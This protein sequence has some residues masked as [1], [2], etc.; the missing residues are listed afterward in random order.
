MTTLSLPRLQPRLQAACVTLPPPLRFAYAYQPI[1]DVERKT[2]FGHEALVRGPEGQPAST[3]LEQVTHAMRAQFES[4]SRD[5]AIA[6]AAALGIE[7]VLS[8]N[9]MPNHILDVDENIEQIL[10]ASCRYGLPTNRLMLETNEGEQVADVKRLVRMMDRCRAFG[11]LAA[12]DDFGGG[13][14]GLSLLANYQP[15]LIKLDM[16]L[17]RNIDRD[18]ARRAIVAGI[19]NMCRE[20]NVAVV[21][22]G[23]ETEG[24]QAALTDLGISLMQGFLFGK[25]M[26]RPF[27]AVRSRLQA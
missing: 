14:S 3:V 15:D 17:V 21:A 13:F 10:A 18:P 9:I 5:K 16:A 8:I 27:G 25:P 20:M 24:E 19:M 7:G 2:V 23:I 6:G 11:M 22:E 4:A 26:F 12:I 1:V